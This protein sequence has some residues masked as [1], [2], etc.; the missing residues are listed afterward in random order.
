MRL[1]VKSAL[2]AACAFF[3]ASCDFG[4]D[5]DSFQNKAGA[6]FKEMTSTAAVAAYKIDTD[7]VQ[8]DRSGNICS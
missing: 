3:F 4:F 2:F 1:F 8:T 6:Y 7:N 5:S